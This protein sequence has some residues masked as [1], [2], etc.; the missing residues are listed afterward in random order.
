V[1]RVDH[2]RV[3]ATADWLLDPS[4][5]TVRRLARAR[6]LDAPQPAEGPTA[7][8]PWIAALLA[9]HRDPPHHPYQKWQGVHWRLVALAELDADATEPEIELVAS[10]GFDRVAR[11]VSGQARLRAS[12][13]IRGRVRQ[14]ASMDGN[15][16]W[17]A[18][19]FGRAGDPRVAAIV[20]RLLG[21]QWPDGGW[22]CDKHPE[23]SHSSFNESLPPLRALAA[24]ARNGDG[25]LA[26]DAA[27]G[28]DRAAEFFLAHCVDRSH[29]TGA[30]AHP[31]VVRRRWPPYW[32]YDRLA[33]LRA[34]REASRLGDPRT[35]AA[36]A[37]LEADR[38]SDG[39]WYPDG[40][41]WRGPG[42]A[43]GAG[44]EALDWTREGE[45]KM[46]TLLALEVLAAR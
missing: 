45:S 26:R 1:L 30:V 2:R 29:R 6:L 11:W 4:N 25:A 43:S 27:A 18:I 8:E 33:G 7:A 20:E 23:A 16:A 17:A 37:D 36:L 41:F 3:T 19:R 13:E 12:R 24:Y 22:N 15:A 46:L 35:K 40:R 21:W 34:L 38:A 5:P 32:H 28:A 14:C 39:R 9:E 31:A 44:I 42:A 10:E